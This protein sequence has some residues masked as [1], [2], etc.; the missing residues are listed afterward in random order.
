MKGM[1]NGGGESKDSKI[2][3]MMSNKNK[4]ENAKDPAS[5]KLL[6]D[7]NDSEAMIY[8]KNKQTVKICDR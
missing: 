1:F 8:G 5:Q 3:Q 2:M 7:I 6:S 4:E